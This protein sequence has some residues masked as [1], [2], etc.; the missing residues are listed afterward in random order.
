LVLEIV[1]IGQDRN[2]RS[3]R[4]SPQG[5]IDGSSGIFI[6]GDPRQL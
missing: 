4:T 3:R 6:G 1:A 2:G 5:K